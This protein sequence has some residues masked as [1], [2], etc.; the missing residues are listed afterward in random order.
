MAT[1]APKG[2]YVKIEVNVWYDKSN[3]SIHITSSDPDLPGTKLHMSAKKGT[4]SDKNL[5]LLLE[6]FDCIAGKP[7][8]PAQLIDGVSLACHDGACKY[9]T[10]VSI[11]PGTVAA[12]Q[13]C[14]HACH[15]TSGTLFSVVVP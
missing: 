6:K 12:T 5:R 15:E 8:H 7:K 9:C 4:Q 10:H 14:G 3:D 1:L 2:T 13:I 11:V